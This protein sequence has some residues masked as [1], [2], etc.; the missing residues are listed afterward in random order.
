MASPS[1]RRRSLHAPPRSAA[2]R[3]SRGGR[4]PSGRISRYDIRPSAPRQ[5]T[6]RTAR[7]RS[8]CLLIWSPVTSFSATTGRFA[9]SPVRPLLW[10]RQRFPRYSLLR[11]AAPRAAPASAPAPNQRSTLWPCDPAA[12]H[13]AR[14]RPRRAVC[15]LDTTHCPWISRAPALTARRARAD[16]VP[17]CLLRTLRRYQGANHTRPRPRRAQRALSV[18]RGAPPG[19]G[20]ALRPHPRR[21]AAGERGAA[22]RQDRRRRGTLRP[23]STC[24]VCSARAARATVVERLTHR[25]R[26]RAWLVTS[27]ETECCQRGRSGGHPRVHRARLWTRRRR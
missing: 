10:P 22:P 27:L 3:R 6:G 7:S 5:R 26:G 24:A 15:P 8:Q 2:P 17:P 13:S 23:R 20:A 19:A 25:S 16:R 4:F 9:T 12:L 18:W 11:A 1:S 21:R 14:T